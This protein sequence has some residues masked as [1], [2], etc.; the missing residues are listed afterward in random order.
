MAGLNKKPPSGRRS[1]RAAL[2]F[3]V[4]PAKA[5]IQLNKKSLGPRFRGGDENMVRGPRGAFGGGGDA[6]NAAL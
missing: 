6:Y 3:I 2:F 4:I 1:E 5:G